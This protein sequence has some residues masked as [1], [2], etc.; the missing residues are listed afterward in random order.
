MTKVPVQISKLHCCDFLSFSQWTSEQRPGNRA[1]ERYK[2]VTWAIK[3]VKGEQQSQISAGKDTNVGASN[4]NVRQPARRPTRAR[5]E[6]QT[7]DW[8][9]MVGGG[10]EMK[11]WGRKL[12]SAIERSRRGPASG[13]PRQSWWD[14][15]A[16]WGPCG[17]LAHAPADVFPGLWLGSGPPREKGQPNCGYS[18]GSAC[19]C[20]PCAKIQA[21]GAL[22]GQGPHSLDFCPHHP[23]MRPP[24]QVTHR[25][26]DPN[27]YKLISKTY[28]WLPIQS[29]HSLT[30]GIFISY[31]GGVDHSGKQ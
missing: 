12:G 1:E 30:G 15:N 24:G 17:A 27:P 10:R 18:H 22:L 20:D 3:E 26:A 21:V 7:A 14:N 16:L 13:L 8:M 4:D 28:P 23:P 2:S 29:W 31:M 19:P 9:T 6:S 5:G 25:W 11:C